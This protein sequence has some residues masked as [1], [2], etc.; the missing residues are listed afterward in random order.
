MIIPSEKEPWGLVVNEA[1]ASKCAIISSSGTGCSKDLVIEDYNGYIYETGD[2]Y[3]LSKI[4]S[5]LIINKNKLETFK[6][7]VWN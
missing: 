2:I 5:K 6:K 7:I 4:I 3:A 1:M